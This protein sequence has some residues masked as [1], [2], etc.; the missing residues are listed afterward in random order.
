MFLLQP[1]SDGGLT[2][3]EYVR[4]GGTAVGDEL[5]AVVSH[6]GPYR[7]KMQKSRAALKKS[8]KSRTGKQLFQSDLFAYQG[9]LNATACPVRVQH[10]MACWSQVPHDAANEFPCRTQRE[11]VERCLGDLVARTV[12]TSS[13]DGNNDG[14]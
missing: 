10:L 5:S 12:R 7:T 14:D 1:A 4:L 9:C 11:A 8:P 13:E 3:D 2:A 6:C